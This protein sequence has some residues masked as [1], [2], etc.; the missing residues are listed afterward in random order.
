MKTETYLNC[1][2]FLTVTLSH[3]IPFVDLR[4]KA[5]FWQLVYMWSILFCALLIWLFKTLKRLRF[6]IKH[7]KRNIYENLEQFFYKSKSQLFYFVCYHSIKYTNIHN[8][9][10]SKL[11]N[12]LFS[13]S[14]FWQREQ[15]SFDVVPL[16]VGAS[17]LKSSAATSAATVDKRNDSKYY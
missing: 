3:A 17:S 5:A 16:M 10:S 4:D 14:S 8:T 1:K 9:F 11:R 2:D 15:F 13:C 12:F 7:W 6:W